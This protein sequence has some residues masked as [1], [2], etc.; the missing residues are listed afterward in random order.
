L[1]EFVNPGQT[2]KLNHMEALELRE[3]VI[4]GK[5]IKTTKL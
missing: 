2:E 1:D 4:P 5:Q 3:T